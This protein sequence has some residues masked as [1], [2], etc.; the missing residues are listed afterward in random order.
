VLRT[1]FEAKKVH[2]CQAEQWDESAGDAFVYRFEKALTD[3]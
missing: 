2:Q 1:L 3:R